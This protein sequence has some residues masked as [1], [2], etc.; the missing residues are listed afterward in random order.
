MSNQ[1]LPGSVLGIFLLPYL[2]LLKAVDVIIFFNP[3]F[4]DEEREV[5]LV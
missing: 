3:Y 2:T 1:S 4:I 5:K